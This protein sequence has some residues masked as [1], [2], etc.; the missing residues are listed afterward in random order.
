MMKFTLIDGVTRNAE[1]PD[2]FEI[3]TE[4]E[5]RCVVPDDLV[6]VGFEMEDED[7]GGE[8]MWVE[9]TSVD[10]EQFTGTLSNHPIVIDLAFGDEVRFGLKHILSIYE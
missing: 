9:V 3:P 7:L 2:T 10:G 5:R 6:K 8:R 4:E 1:N